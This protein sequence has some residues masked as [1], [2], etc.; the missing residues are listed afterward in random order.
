MIGIKKLNYTFLLI[1]VV[2]LNIPQMVTAD[3]KFRKTGRVSPKELQ[4]IDAFYEKYKD[5]E[6]ICSYLA[7]RTFHYLKSGKKDFELKLKKLKGL[8]SHEEFV[9][10]YERSYK[11]KITVVSEYD[12]DFPLEHKRSTVLERLS[13]MASGQAFMVAVNIDGEAT[14]GGHVLIVYNEGG[15]M[16]IIENQRPTKINSYADFITLISSRDCTGIVLMDAHYK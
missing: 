11:T 7:E 10:D 5:A 15:N 6:N 9:M 1:L 8:R 4:K 3:C 2:G 16:K 13:R 14:S 12:A